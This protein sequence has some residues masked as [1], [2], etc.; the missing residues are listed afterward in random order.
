VAF[1]EQQAVGPWRAWVTVIANP[2]V[3][4][5]YRSELRLYNH[6]EGPSITFSGPVNAIDLSRVHLTAAGV[7]LIDK[8]LFQV[9]ILRVVIK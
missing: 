3:A 4:N 8:S 9:C 1:L 2:S 7:F 5:E 6:G